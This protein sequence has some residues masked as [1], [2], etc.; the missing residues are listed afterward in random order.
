MSWQLTAYATRFSVRT[1]RPTAVA[2][3]AVL[4]KPQA[5]V[6]AARELVG[7]LTA[8][9]IGDVAVLTTGPSANRVSAGIYAAEKV[10][11]VRRDALTASGFDFEVL[12]RSKSPGKFWI[13]VQ[14]PADPAA[15]QHYAEVIASAGPDLKRVVVPCEQQVAARN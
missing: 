4:S 9:R 2:D 8:A 6:A 3:Y 5:S 12:P 1:D 11:V 14:A 13:D 10:A 7:R 15:F